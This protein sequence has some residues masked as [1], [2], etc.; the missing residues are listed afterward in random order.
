MID[1]LTGERLTIQNGHLILAAAQRPRVDS[2]LK[3]HRC[4]AVWSAGISAVERYVD[5]SPDDMRNVAVWSVAFDESMDI[6]TLQAALD[7][8]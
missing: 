2:I 5:T 6:D 8:E 3:E 7:A 4:P 1:D